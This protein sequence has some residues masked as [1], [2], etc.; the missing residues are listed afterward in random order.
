MECWLAKSISLA[1]K[2][3]DDKKRME[4]TVGGLESHQQGSYHQH[5]PDEDGRI[6]DNEEL[7]RDE[8]GRWIPNASGRPE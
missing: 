5:W 7:H 8:D 4:S 6:E 1:N 2:L 3:V